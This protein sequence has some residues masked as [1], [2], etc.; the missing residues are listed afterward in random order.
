MPAFNSHNPKQTLEV[1]LLVE[2]HGEA[3]DRSVDQQTSNN[4]HCHGRDGN[5]AAV[6]QQYRQGY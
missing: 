6:G 5:H 3:Y 2:E 4:R 1:L